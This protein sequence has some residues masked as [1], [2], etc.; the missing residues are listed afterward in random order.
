MRARGWRKIASGL[1]GWPAD[2][3]IYGRLDIDATPILEAVEVLRV[4]TGAHVTPTTLAV[5]GIAIALRTNPELNTR[6]VHGHFIPRR[7][8]DVFV[9]TSTGA[10]RDLSGVKV[11]EADRRAIGE[12]AADVAA[13]AVDARAGGSELERAKRLLEALPPSILRAV[14]RAAA[15]VTTDLGIDLSALGMPREAFG[16]AMVSSVGMFGIPEGWSPLS[17][18]YRVPVL[19]LV[20]ETRERPWAVDGRV[21]VRPVI[22]LTATIDHRWVDAHG[23]AGLARSFRR[24]LADPLSYEEMERPLQPSTTTEARHR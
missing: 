10:G 18:M 7:S 5:R 22:T 21:E 20:G 15:F 9:I 23:I 12:I 19:V 2:P 24:Y 11:R 17:F 13:G 8:V 16:S 3:Q 1:W 4:R 6:F 14:L